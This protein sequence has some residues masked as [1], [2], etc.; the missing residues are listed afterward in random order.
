M[1][2]IKAKHIIRLEK[3]ISEGDIINI[4]DLESSSENMADSGSETEKK[5]LVVAIKDNGDVVT[6]SRKNY[7]LIHENIYS[8]ERNPDK[9]GW[10]LMNQ[11]T[12]IHTWPSP[13]YEKNDKML[14]EAGLVQNGN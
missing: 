4:S 12:Y 14:N 7:P 1:E 3:A 10:C 6:I 8:L 13:G 11:R 5:E 9:D 2:I